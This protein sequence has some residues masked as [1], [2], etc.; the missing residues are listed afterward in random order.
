MDVIPFRREHL[1][2]FKPQPRQAGVLNAPAHQLAELEKSYS[3]SVFKDGECLAIGGF[4]EQWA[5]RWL[6]WCALSRTSGKDLVALTRVALRHLATLKHQRV[7]ASVE[8]DFEEGHRWLTFLGFE[9]DA[10]LMR[11][12]VPGQDHALYSR[13]S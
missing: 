8:A 2:G 1:K 9:C 6:A 4:V 11:E 13:V 10:P 7:E 5:G 3:F 12:Y